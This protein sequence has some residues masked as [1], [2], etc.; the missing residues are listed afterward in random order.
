[1]TTESSLHELSPVSTSHRESNMNRLTFR[2]VYRRQFTVI[3]CVPVILC[4]LAGFS[5]LAA[6]ISMNLP[7]GVDAGRTVSGVAT[8]SPVSAGVEV[9]TFSSSNNEI[10]R[11]L[12]TSM[13]IQP[14]GNQATTNVLGVSAGC[15][16]ITATHRTLSRN[17]HLVVQPP[18]ASSALKLSVTSDLVPLGYGI[19][20]RLSRGAYGTAT[21]TLSSS[22]PAVLSV[23]ASVTT[24][25]GTVEF[26]LT[27]RKDGC[28]IVTA[29]Y[30]SEVTSRTIRVADIGG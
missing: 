26:V 11:P 20:G 7:N 23:P 8:I 14:G 18:P 17:A 30:R 13:P 4:S 3:A 9:V 15:A 25:G 2:F 10:A 16:S 5:R 27:G 29:Q 24:N 22:D 6:S 1:M 21:V 12:T 19:K 28:A